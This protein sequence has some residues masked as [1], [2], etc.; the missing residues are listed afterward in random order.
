MSVK[1]FHA[2][3]WASLFCAGLAGA[4][5][6]AA[7]PSPAQDDGARPA[8]LIIAYKAAPKDRAAF[9]NWWRA[10]GVGR[11]ARW[12][13]Q[14]VFTDSRILFSSYAGAE[15]DA[16]AIIDFRHFTD[17]RRWRNIEAASPGGL[18]STALRYGAPAYTGLGDALAHGAAAQAATPAYLVTFYDVSADPAAYRAYVSGYVEPQMAGW[19]Q[20]G[21]LARY[22]MYVNENTAGAP[23]QSMLVL[24][25]N[26]LEGL[27]RRESVKTEVRR[28]LAA[29]PDWK[30]LSDNKAEVRKEKAVAEFEL[31]SG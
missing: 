27:A 11:F 26:G 6:A 30:R 18:T 21:A 22:D 29:N 4:L 8:T 12:R 10:A 23:W 9:R 16:L 2:R 3:G 5:L 1:C 31:I 19:M 7:A 14:G 13:Q 25:Y 28:A 20:A 24:D 17:L 15:Y